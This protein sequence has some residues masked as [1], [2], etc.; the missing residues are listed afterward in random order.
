MNRIDV[1]NSR[2]A[3]N[4]STALGRYKQTSLLLLVKLLLLLSGPALVLTEILTRN[5]QCDRLPEIAQKKST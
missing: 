1:Q 4:N 2:K 3:A 5:L